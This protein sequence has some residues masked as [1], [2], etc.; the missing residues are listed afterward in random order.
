MRKCLV[1]KS[2]SVLVLCLLAVCMGLSL[3]PASAQTRNVMSWGQNVSSWNPALGV[4]SMREG[5]SIV[6]TS[7]EPYLDNLATLSG[8]KTYYVSFPISPS[9]SASWA[10][11][12]S[13]L[14]LSHPMMREIDFDDFVGKL[15]DEEE[16]GELTAAEAPAFV[17]SVIAATKSANPKL[18]F[19]I[20]LYEDMFNHASLYA[21]PASVLA[22]I[23]YVHLYVHFREDAP[24]WASYVTKTKSLFPNATIIA[25]AYPYDR[26]N[27]IACAYETT[28][29]CTVA[30]EQSLYQELLQSQLASINAGTVMGVEFYPGYFG[31]PQTWGGWTTQACQT[32]RL[33]QCI[34]NTN[35]LQSITLQVLKSTPSSTGA[36]AAATGASF[37]LSPTSLSFGSQKE[38][39]QSSFQRVM[40]T[41]TSSSTTVSFGTINYVGDFNTTNNCPDNLVAGNSCVIWVTFTPRELGTRTGSVTV[42][43]NANGVALAPQTVAAS[44]TGIN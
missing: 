44:G 35:T 29:P 24:N 18:A 25:G 41:N 8:A 36:Q 3:K 6:P 21:F 34:S 14:S 10:A 16:A 23:S 39:V 40:V 43:L 27:Y 32:A 5:C 7:C 1:C 33:S 17:T 11:Q 9:T 38:D 26:I 31:D 22:Q 20:T 42:H 28:V 12:Y 13:T 4:N 15:E 37:T 30:Q 19:G 2:R